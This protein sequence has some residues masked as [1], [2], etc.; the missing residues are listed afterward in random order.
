MKPFKTLVFAALLVFSLA[1]N[2]FAGDVDVPVAPAP[3]PPPRLMIA[4]AP[5]IT[6]TTDTQET[7]AVTSDPSD[8]LFYEALAALLSVY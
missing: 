2:T 8:Y 7:E 4:Q 6:G 1:V 3:P 5:V